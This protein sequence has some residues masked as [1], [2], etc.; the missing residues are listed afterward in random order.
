[1]RM[2]IKS[3]HADSHVA[4]I[5]DIRINKKSKPPSKR[6]SIAEISPEE[7]KFVIVDVDDYKK[8]VETNRSKYKFE[9]TSSKQSSHRE[10]NNGSKS[11]TKAAQR[12][13]HSMIE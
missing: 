4:G 1:M 8:W 10:R 11:R 2:N 12:I 3:N 13:N 7:R 5:V 6:Q 9:P